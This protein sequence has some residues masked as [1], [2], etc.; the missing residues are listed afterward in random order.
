MASVRQTISVVCTQTQ[1]PRSIHVASTWPMRLIPTSDPC[2]HTLALFARWSCGTSFTVSHDIFALHS[3]RRNLEHRTS[4]FR[5]HLEHRHREQEPD[6][7]C[8]E[9]P[10]QARQHAIT[11]LLGP[12]PLSGLH[13]LS[14]PHATQ[15]SSYL[16]SYNVDP[17]HT[18]PI[19]TPRGIYTAHTSWPPTPHTPWTP[20]LHILWTPWPKVTMSISMSM[21]I[22]MLHA[23]TRPV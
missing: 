7:D 8:W 11:H 14:G 10:L 15:P 1:P 16:L 20:T 4:Y 17:A 13:P 18:G 2:P 6:G 3:L 23:E 12:N 22:S 19:L 5:R 9:V 21:P